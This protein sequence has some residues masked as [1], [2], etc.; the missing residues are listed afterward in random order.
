[1]EKSEVRVE[2]QYTEAEYLAATRLLFFNAPNILVRLIVLGLLLL[3]GAVMLSVV[4]TDL[5]PLW[6][7]VAFVMLI[8]G[9]LF[10]NLL[11]RMPRAYFRGDGKFRD[12]YEVT[13]SDE[14]IMVKTS[15]IDSKLAWSLYTRVL[16]GRDMYLLVYGKDTRMMTVV[17][18]RAFKNRDQENQFRE[19]VARHIIDHSGFKQI[20]PG[21]SEYRPTSFTPPDWR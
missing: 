10:Y 19:L 3:A 1:M 12:K 18:R 4:M 7:I 16:E 11:V 5:F 9:G 8:E 17:P 14:G 13:F 21:E 15:Q 2:Y 6:A 20:P